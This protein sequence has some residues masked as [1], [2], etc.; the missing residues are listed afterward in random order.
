MKLLYNAART[1]NEE[2]V[3]SQWN[4]VKSRLGT[5]VIA[6]FI[7]WIKVGRI[8]SSNSRSS[9]NDYLSFQF[10]FRNRKFLSS[11]SLFSMLN[12][13]W[14]CIFGIFEEQVV[15]HFCSRLSQ[16]R[17][18]S[19]LYRFW[20][21]KVFLQMQEARIAR[22]ISTQLPNTAASL[23]ELLGKQLLFA[24]EWKFVSILW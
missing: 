21:S 13:I 3:Q 7:Y 5:K 6:Y 17:I 2:D 16:V 15:F 22:Q 24:V 19:S 23:H 12:N 9:T 4:S 18:S 11:R 1:G 20:S 14:S 8:F 10:R